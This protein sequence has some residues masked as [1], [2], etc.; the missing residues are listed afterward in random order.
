M[1]SLEATSFGQRRTNV[2][3]AGG[4]LVL[5]ARAII[6][7]SRLLREKAAAGCSSP[8]VGLAVSEQR[9]KLY[10]RLVERSENTVDGFGQGLQESINDQQS[11]P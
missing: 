2:Q 7:S 11:S 10:S 9:E 5:H 6:L 8:G 1:D 4:V 3:V